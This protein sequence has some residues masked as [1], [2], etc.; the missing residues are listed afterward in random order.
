MSSF[1]IDMLDRPLY[2]FSSTDRLLK[3][4]AGTARR[5]IDGYQRSESAYPP[6]IRE[7]TTGDET[8]TWGEFVECRYLVEYREKK[9]PMVR[10]RPAVQLLKERFDTQYPLATHKPFVHGQELVLRAQV[11]SEIDPS[12]YLVVVRNDQLV[13]STAAK[14]FESEIEWTGSA[15]AE[16]ASAMWPAGRSSAV[17]IDPQ[18]GFGE[19]VVRNTRTEILARF[20]TGGSP[21]AELAK[22]YELELSE[23]RDA[24]TYEGRRVA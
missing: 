7:S 8:V 22:M 6:V 10:M 12:F 24:L 19:P 16:F 23:V 1:V 13:L 15:G 18:R 20:F 4:T 2:T 21:L 14:A 11:E 5:W 17:R 9:V 3:L